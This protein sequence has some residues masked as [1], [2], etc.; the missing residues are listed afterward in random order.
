MQTLDEKVAEWSAILSTREEENTKLFEEND[1]LKQEL[2]TLK[3]DKDRMSVHA[4]VMTMKEK[5]DQ[6]TCL[7][8][9]L[10]D[11]AREV[12]ESTALLGEVKKGLGPEESEVLKIERMKRTQ[13]TLKEKENLILEME[14]Q[15]KLLETNMELKDEEI[16]TLEERLRGYETGEYGLAEAISEWKATKLELVAK[17]RQLD[18]VC[19]AAGQAES[20]ASQLLLEN[21]CL[22]QRLNISP[23]ED[24]NIDGFVSQRRVKEDETKAL[25]IV[26]Q[27]EIEKLENE[28]LDLKQKLRKMARQLVQNSSINELSLQSILSSEAACEEKAQ[29]EWT[30]ALQGA[31]PITEVPEVW[32]SRIKAANDEISRLAT[33]VEKERLLQQKTATKMNLLTELNVQLEAGLSKLQETLKTCTKA[34]GDS[35]VILECPVLGKL[36]AA[37]DARSIMED[38]DNTRFL[39]CR[40][41]YLEGSNDEL[42]RELQ[43]TRLVAAT[44][45]LQ[46]DAQTERLTNLEMQLRN[47]AGLLSG[48]LEQLLVT[49]QIAATALPP[50]LSG[51]SS[52]TIAALE[53]H[54][55][56]AL[57]ELEEKSQQTRKLER[58]L[59][60]LRRKFALCR[61]K[62][63]LLYNDFL[64]ERKSWN[65]ERSTLEAQMQQLTAEK[66]E[67]TVYKEEL[68]SYLENCKKTEESSD[69]EE[70]D[71]HL[72]EVTREILKLRINEG[73]M[74]RKYTS[75]SDQLVSLEKERN[76]LRNDLIHHE[77]ACMAR[78]G[79]YSRLKELSAFQFDQLQKQ[80]DGTVPIGELVELRRQFDELTAKY[81][82]LLELQ[83]RADVERSAST[84]AKA[85]F[86]RLSEEHEAVKAQL[87]V[88]K[89]RLY[90][91]ESSWV[92]VG[93]KSPLSPDIASE[94]PQS[95]GSM[96]AM[97]K[98][99]ATAELRELN[100]RERANHL[101]AM[102]AALKTACDQ[103]EQRNTELEQKV[104][105]LTKTCLEQQ[106]IEASLRDEL[107]EAAPKEVYEACK[108]RLENLEQAELKVRLENEA[109]KEVSTIAAAQVKA[110]NDMKT[111]AEKEQTILKSVITELESSTD[112]KAAMARL[113]RQITRLQISEATAVRRL[114]AANDKITR[115]DNTILRLEKNFDERNCTLIHLQN[116]SRTRERRLRSTIANLRSRFAGCIPLPEQ[117]RLARLLTNYMKECQRLRECLEVSEREHFQAL[118]EAVSAKE[119][120]DLSAEAAD[121]LKGEPNQFEF[122]A[123]L[124]AKLVEWQGK[125]A[126][127]RA[128]EAVQ[129]RQSE[130]SRQLMEHLQNVV[131]TQEDQI[132]QLDAENARLSKELDQQEMQWERREEELAAVLS[133]AEKG[134]VRRNKTGL[135]SSEFVKTDVPQL[136]DPTQPMEKQ[137]EAAVDTI[138]RMSVAQ[139]GLQQQLEET[140]GHIREVNSVIQKRE[141]VAPRFNESPLAAPS[142]AIIQS[143]LQATQ[144]APLESSAVHAPPRVTV[145]LPPPP[146]LT[147][148]LEA[149]HQRLASKEASL[150]RT[151]DLLREAHEE[152]QQL[153]QNHV[154]EVSALQAQLTEEKMKV[155]KLSQP[156]ILSTADGGNPADLDLKRRVQL[157]E[158]SMRE[159]SEAA[160]QQ[161]SRYHEA[162][163]ESEAWRLKFTELQSVL[164]AKLKK[165]DETHQNEKEDLEGRLRELEQTVETRNL[166][167]KEL[168]KAVKF[169]KR[170]VTRSPDVLQ[171][172][173]IAKVQ[174]EVEEK[175][176]EHQMLMTSATEE[177][178]SLPPAEDVEVN[179]APFMQTNQNAAP[180]SI[181]EAVPVNQN[182]PEADDLQVKL[183]KQTQ[184]QS[185]FASPCNV[186]QEFIIHSSPD[187][188]AHK[189][190]TLKNLKVK[191]DE[192]EEENKVLKAELIR[193]K[194]FRVMTVDPN[195]VRELNQKIRKL[196]EENSRLKNAA[197]KP[198]E[199][200]FSILKVAN[201]TTGSRGKPENSDIEERRISV[202]RSRK[203]LEGELQQTQELLKASQ[204]EV[205]VLRTKL[206][207]AQLY[208]Q[209]EDEKNTLIVKQPRK[210]ERSCPPEDLL[211]VDTS[212]FQNT[213][214]VT[215][216]Q[217]L[218]RSKSEL[219]VSP[220]TELHRSIAGDLDTQIDSIKLHNQLLQERVFDLEKRL[221]SSGLSTPS[222]IHLD[223]LAQKEKLNYASENLQLRFDLE[224]AR[225]EASRLK[226][227]VDELERDPRLARRKDQQDAKRKPTVSFSVDS[228]T[229]STSSIRKIGES[230]K[231]TKELEKIIAKMKKV[232]DR[233]LAENEQLRCTPEAV[234]QEQLNRL[235][236]EKEA[237]K[238]EL[239]KSRE[240]AEAELTEQRR[241]AEVQTAR[242]GREYEKL[243]KELEKERKAH[244]ETNSRLVRS[245]YHLSTLE[246][247]NTQL[248]ERLQTMTK[249]RS[250]FHGRVPTP[251]RPNQGSALPHSARR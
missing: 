104:A 27:G 131:R 56:I 91:L 94:Q 158:A 113:H 248:Q 181:V 214:L 160:I 116:Q 17:E 203:R 12:S 192:L 16:R 159:Q 117:E 208:M 204:K 58:N 1:R 34:S 209:A 54:L 33:E 224:T 207:Q 52:E 137:L 162:L 215:A 74:M 213:D 133:I 228:D 196:E 69:K 100:E 197:E 4:L 177:T 136:P 21:D 146:A 50:G 199:D 97:A 53:E 3:I 115:L 226:S 174:S 154:T 38:S 164:Q 187:N 101:Q 139:Q 183:V 66:T 179:I 67:L 155:A 28:R 161:T 163:R 175:E 63:G 125:L 43:E 55:V 77:S 144:A 13:K 25:N 36:L 72:G 59:D 245:Q 105:E 22:R 173:S 239:K 30:N 61:H 216:V 102:H 195:L 190:A 200:T 150:A 238:T 8:E 82:E 122:Q 217:P 225:L 124:S 171:K 76:R 79:Y 15:I 83:G 184:Q 120:S 10:I 78:V 106:K 230:G 156:P 134:L 178:R 142:S 229:S 45:Q 119:R 96:Q 194:S 35:A 157:L 148:A 90:I 11:A 185:S 9:Q 140:N 212:P 222:Q 84:E 211:V 81:R 232:L 112:E 251:R 48:S 201:E 44:A 126:E 205:E 143:E 149:A 153:Q 111:D 191:F 145:P 227:R 109:L 138:R 7:K 247:E 182:K 210:L 86:Q 176:V 170:R 202:W 243:R 235:L 250:G 147:E 240:T 68:L 107:S 87:V 168:T 128:S 57:N 108:E 151:N 219:V 118:S 62:Q 237:I 129:Q 152:I 206:T 5:D 23:S 65:T 92:A 41:D 89:E 42:R 19:Q 135:V 37:L 47:E 198:Y 98:A 85:R 242:L 166:Q 60:D 24:I 132:A 75:V 114:A 121:L 70:R 172:K 46:L 64:V 141:S 193:R 244:E 188:S 236:S 93:K 2:E 189:E 95:E 32:Q 249:D 73:V 14:N 130:R 6:I 29:G 218:R 231:S 246:K 51:N 233:T 103:L 165:R 99:L 180:M 31:A 18:E 20:N 223:R 220:S 123:G 39:K 49:Q 127:L 40:V 80:L 110:F 241:Q 221:V 167:I 169:L 234:S 186:R 71:R 26:L 88:A